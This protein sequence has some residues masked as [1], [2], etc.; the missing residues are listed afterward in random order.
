MALGKEAGSRIRFDLKLQDTR[1][2][3][4][5]AV[6]SQ[7][8]TE[9]DL[10]ELVASTGQALRGQLAL[11]DL[12]PREREGLRAAQPKADVARLYA[13][14]LGQLRVEACSSARGPLEQAVAAEPQFPQAHSA[15]AEALACLGYQDRALDEARRAVELSQNRPEHVRLETQARLY[16]LGKEPEKAIDVYSAL[17]VRFPDNFDYGYKL[18]LLQLTHLREAD[19]AQTMSALRKL[20]SP[21]SDDPRLDLLQAMQLYFSGKSDEAL[22]IVD[23][24]RARAEDQGARLVAAGAQL[25]AAHILRHLGRTDD[26]LES[27]RRARVI[28]EAASDQDGVAAAVTAEASMR[29]GDDDG[30]FRQKAEAQIAGIGQAL[31]NPKEMMRFKY[32]IAGRYA[33]KGDNAAAARAYGDALEMARSQKD[34]S[35]EIQVGQQLVAVLMERDL[36]AARALAERLIADGGDAPADLRAGLQLLRI[37]LENEQGDAAAARRDA[38]DVLRSAPSAVVR[39]QALLTKSALAND[40]RSFKEAE[41]L[42]R[43]AL[44]AT[45]LLAPMANIELAEALIGQRRFADADTVIK[46]IGHSPFFRSPRFGFLIAAMS[47]QVKAQTDLGEARRDLEDKIAK[48]RAL[49]YVSSVFELQ[50]RLGQVELDRGD[51]R[52]G[53]TLLA[54]VADEA[55]RL[56]YLRIADRAARPE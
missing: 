18:A 23:S 56:G 42:A 44:E 41:Q 22:G 14:G 5:V 50:L 48:A 21:A 17:F 40:A 9:A 20:P 24:A 7:T 28:F 52:K 45:A 55:R 10:M 8:G 30:E 49:G 2:G 25:T 54:S 6:L 51:R 4:T 53:Q 43:A 11:G 27:A 36:T 38:D 13:E 46:A 12:S 26:A 32:V 37:A 29:D 39:A 16:E 33:E 3:E 1:T 31:R 47:D 35:L 19:F 15:L 34:T